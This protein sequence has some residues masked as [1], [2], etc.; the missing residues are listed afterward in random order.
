MVHG[1]G[2]L[3]IGRAIWENSLLI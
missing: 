2:Q 1:S 3:S